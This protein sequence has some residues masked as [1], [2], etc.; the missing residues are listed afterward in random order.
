MIPYYF[1]ENFI[2]FQK[3]EFIGLSGLI[4]IDYAESRSDDEII[5]ARDDESVTA[6][7]GG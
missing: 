5:A 3:K 4:V 7:G 1:C 6:D 2:S